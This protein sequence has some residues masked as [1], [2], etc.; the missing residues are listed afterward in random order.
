[1]AED[2]VLGNSNPNERSLQHLQLNDLTLI[3]AKRLIYT[4]GPPHVDRFWFFYR[5]DTEVCRVLT[6]ETGPLDMA[7]LRGFRRAVHVL[8]KLTPT[9]TISPLTVERYLDLGG[10]LHEDVH[11]HGRPQEVKG[12][13]YVERHLDAAEL[14][15]LDAGDD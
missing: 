2:L 12:Q 8:A 3:D 7:Y 10:I 4:S 9:T 14:I 15:R 6:G 13:G 1:M 5:V 11:V